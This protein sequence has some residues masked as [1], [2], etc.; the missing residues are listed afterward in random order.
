MQPVRDD[1]NEFL[2]QIEAI[3]VSADLL[4]DSHDA[5]PEDPFSDRFRESSQDFYDVCGFPMTDFD[6]FY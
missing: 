4:D 6:I 3:E 2:N 5:V 1:R